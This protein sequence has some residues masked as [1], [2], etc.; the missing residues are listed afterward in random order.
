MSK[1]SDD[2]AIQ[3]LSKRGAVPPWL[4]HT[5]GWAKNYHEALTLGPGWSDFDRSIAQS[6]PIRG[7]GPEATETTIT[8]PASV[9]VF[10][11]GM[12]EAIDAAV[13][14][15]DAPDQPIS[16]S[17]QGIQQA[18]MRI[19]QLIGSIRDANMPMFPVMADPWNP[20]V[21]AAAHFCYL[22]ELSHIKLEHRSHGATPNERWSNEFKADEMA[23]SAYALT[24]RSHPDLQARLAFF[25]PVLALYFGELVGFAYTGTLDRLTD[26][27]PPI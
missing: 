20:G 22:H 25:G 10:M 4:S 21:I 1:H 26:A 17:W 11:R 13:E 23:F 14:Y 9:P 3:I 16:L 27:H 18:A 7:S 19:A 12:I 8:M 2:E 6:D 24:L 15:S 5:R